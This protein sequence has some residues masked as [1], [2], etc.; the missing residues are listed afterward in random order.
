MFTK[1][2]I[3]TQEKPHC[4]CCGSLGT[5]LYQDLKDRLF[6]ALGSWNVKQCNNKE[7]GLLWLDPSPINEDLAIAYQNYYT[8]HSSPVIK[9]FMFEKLIA[10]YRA[11]QYDY[12]V[13]R[14]NAIQRGLGKVLSFFNFFKEHMDYPF[15]YFKQMRKGRLLELGV[16]SGDTLKLFKNWDW[17]VEG[18]DF[19]PQAVKHASSQG[20][21]VYQGDVFSQNFPDDSFDAIFSSHVLE[22]VP[23]PVALMRESLRILKPGG[24]FVAVTPNA[25]SKLHGIYKTNWRGLEPPRH[26]Y[27]F[28]PKALLLAAKNSGL[29][30]IEIVSSNCSAI[31]IFYTSLQLAQRSE[32]KHFSFIKSRA[33]LAGWYLN[34]LHRF[35]P[36]SG[37]ELVLIAYK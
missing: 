15:V 14:T 23:D 1:Q 19:D 20:L 4:I 31:H 17:Q 16:G 18:L 21:K 33:Y 27:I 8:H 32:K 3:R 13:A 25:A 7:C 26:L 30:K 12:Q 6:G 36:L 34:L 24:V 9:K 11:F 10:G 5:S 2:Q 35:S 29:N 28:N 37:E 22:H